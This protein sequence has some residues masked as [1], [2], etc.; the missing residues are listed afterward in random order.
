MV[1]VWRNNNCFLVRLQIGDGEVKMSV[2]RIEQSLFVGSTGDCGTETSAG[3]ARTDNGGKTSLG[4]E[5]ITEFVTDGISCSRREVVSNRVCGL[6]MVHT[7]WETLSRKDT[8]KRE[9]QRENTAAKR[10]IEKHLVENGT[11]GN[12]E[13]NPGEQDNKEMWHSNQFQDKKQSKDKQ[14]NREHVP[15]MNRRATA[16]ENLQT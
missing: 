10:K 7:G 14:E 16:S 4:G 5:R 13:N 8:M 6:A 12:T 3:E 2:T 11:T 15:W 9:T 1:A